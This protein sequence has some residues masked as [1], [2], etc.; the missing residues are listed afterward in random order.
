M[1]PGDT[2]E[3]PIFAVWVAGGCDFGDNTGDENKNKVGFWV[4]GVP[5]SRGVRCCCG[6]ALAKLKSDWIFNAVTVSFLQI[7]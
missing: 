3:V 2:Q 4:G 7:P 5:G 6:R 1:S